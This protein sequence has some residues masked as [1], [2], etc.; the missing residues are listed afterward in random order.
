MEKTTN[1]LNNVLKKTKPDQVG[2]FLENNQEELIVEKKP[3]ARYMRMCIRERGMQQQEV[4]IRADLSESYG[5]KIIS[6]EKHTNQRDTII[7]LCIG[8]KLSLEET[9]R[10]LKIYGMSPLYS[11]IPREAA[12][13]VALNNG[14]TDVEDVNTLLKKNN[15]I[16]LKGT[17][18]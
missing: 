15:M 11:R 13:I 18:S 12:I 1:T 14:M 6:E 8:A 10:A 2:T 16:P 7:R 5:Y 17:E 9:Q 3:F 4:F